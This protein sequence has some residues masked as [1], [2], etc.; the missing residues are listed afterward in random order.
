METVLRV[1]VVYVCLMA[2]LRIIGK[3]E[4]SKLSP[5]ELVTLLLIPELLEPGMIGENHSLINGLAGVATLFCLVFANSLLSYR[6]RSIRRLTEGEPTVLVRAG[7]LL[8]DNLTR[9]RIPADEIFSEMHK[10][11]LE[12]IADVKWGILE[13]DGHMSFV[14]YGK[15][16]AAAP[17]EGDDEP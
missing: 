8:L 2:G 15:E 6:Y 16:G 3:R 10:S 11:G 5:F 17:N 13:T 4:L 12:H 7:E 1:V 14:P 9:E